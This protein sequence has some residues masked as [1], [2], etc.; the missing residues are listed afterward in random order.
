MRFSC[1]GNPEGLGFL[2]FGV[3]VLRRLGFGEVDLQILDVGVEE[4]VG[5]GCGI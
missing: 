3:F 4:L 5:L 1:R 2:G